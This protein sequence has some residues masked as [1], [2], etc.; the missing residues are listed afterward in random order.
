MCTATINTRPCACTCPKFD[1]RTCTGDP[2]KV[3]CSHSYTC[4]LYD[5]NIEDEL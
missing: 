1:G 5:R 2:N 3:S 4:P